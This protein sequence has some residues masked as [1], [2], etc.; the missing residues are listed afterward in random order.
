MEE[1][2]RNLEFVGAPGSEISN[3]GKIRNIKTGKYQSFGDN[4][5]YYRATLYIPELYEQGKKTCCK[6]FLVAR[7]VALAFIPNPDNKPEIDHIDGDRHNNRAD[8]LRWVTHKEN[9]KNPV[10][11]KR[12]KDA[13]GNKDVRKRI[14]DSVKSTLNTPEMHCKL[15]KIHKN[16]W[17][18]PG[19]KDKMKSIHSC[20]KKWMNNG[21]EEMLVIPPWDQD[22]LIF[23]WQYGRLKK[24]KS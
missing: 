2:W 20:N 24:E 3:T 6:H 16:Q 12:C 10:T 11:V 18:K 1:I 5:G 4:H 7:L 17:S 23:G 15:S 22:M 9:V 13:M 8:N 14:S 21:K 19:Y